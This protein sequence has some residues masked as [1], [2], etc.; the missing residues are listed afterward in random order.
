MVPHFSDRTT[1]KTN[2]A[3]L[4]APGA[5]CPLQWVGDGA[6]FNPTMVVGHI[7]GTS[8]TLWGSVL[9]AMVQSSLSS[10]WFFYFYETVLEFQSNKS[11]SILLGNARNLSLWKELC[12]SVHHTTSHKFHQF[13]PLFSSPTDTNFTWVN[14]AA[15]AFFSCFSW[16]WTIPTIIEDH[17]DH[18]ISSDSDVSMAM[19][20]DPIDWRYRF[21]I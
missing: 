6:H 1:S 10:T 19:T 4:Q 17:K 15:K 13:L 12:S 2:M 5:H 7:T 20:Q 16:T 21:H 11:C 8:T 9:F 18:P 3:P 14:S